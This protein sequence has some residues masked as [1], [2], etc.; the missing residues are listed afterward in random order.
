MAMSDVQNQKKTKWQIFL[1]NLNAFLVWVFYDVV[2]DEPVDRGVA[3][4]KMNFRF[5]PRLYVW[6]PAIILLSWFIVICIGVVGFGEFVRHNV[7]VQDFSSYYF[8]VK[9]TKRPSKWAAYKKF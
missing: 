1:L 8:M 6:W 4:K 9:G 5:F 3:E 2:F 7:R